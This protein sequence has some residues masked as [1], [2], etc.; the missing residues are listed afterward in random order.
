MIPGHDFKT[1]TLLRIGLAALALRGGLQLLLDHTGHSSNLTDFALG[2]MLGLGA[3][4][5]LIVAWR[6]GR[7]LRGQ[8]TGTCPE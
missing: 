2:V 8:S 1:G 4:L 5:L 7:R 6:N 3:T